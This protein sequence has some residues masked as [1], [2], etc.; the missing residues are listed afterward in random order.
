MAV[1]GTVAT[2]WPA[3]TVT[4]SATEAAVAVAGTEPAATA[5]GELASRTMGGTAIRASTLRYRLLMM[6]LDMCMRCPSRVDM[7]G[8]VFPRAQAAPS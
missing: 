4:V 1:D 3:F 5:P 6:L 2:D 8:P 7:M